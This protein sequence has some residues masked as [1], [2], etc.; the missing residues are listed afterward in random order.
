MKTIT[1]TQGFETS[2]DDED[3]DWL[4]QFSWYSH[5]KKR[6]STIVYAVRKDSKKTVSMAKSILVRHGLWI[7]GYEI[8]HIDG[9]RL[10]NQKSN[11]R[12]ATSSQNQANQLPRIA[13]SKYKGVSWESSRS[14]WRADIRVNRRRI[15]LGR[16]NSE[17]DAA[18]A[19]DIK[20]LEVFGSFS[21]INFPK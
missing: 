4:R 7:E 14:M 3:I 5:V 21:K 17:I 15:F 1:L 20:A 2:V 12:L 11:L 8:D 6:K 10:N 9:N 19:Y 16:Y 13:S 18:I